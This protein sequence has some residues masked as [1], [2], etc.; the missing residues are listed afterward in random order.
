LLQKQVIVA[1]ITKLHK[2]VIVE[3]FDNPLT[4]RTDD[5]YGRVINVASIN[6]D[7]L[8]HQQFNNSTTQQLNNSTTQ[9]L[10]N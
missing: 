4:D 5:R 1:F 6:K 10:N 3:L 2:A 9:Q 7:T 8:L